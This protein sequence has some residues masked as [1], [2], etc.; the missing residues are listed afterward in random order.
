MTE[1]EGLVHS[2]SGTHFESNKFYFIYTEKK[3]V[4]FLDNILF[5]KHWQIIKKDYL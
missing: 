2:A 4:L 1:S 5:L 3:N